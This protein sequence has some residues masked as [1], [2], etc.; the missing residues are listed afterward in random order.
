MT[1]EEKLKEIEDFCQTSDFVE[2]DV[3]DGLRLVAA[4]RLAIEQRDSYITTHYVNSKSVDCVNESV[5]NNAAL[6][7]VLSND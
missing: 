6:L 2:I 1:L 7:K 5:A 4:L 3:V